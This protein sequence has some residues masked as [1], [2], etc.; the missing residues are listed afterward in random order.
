VFCGR[1][2]DTRYDYYNESNTAGDI[3]T[4]T[5]T[6]FIGYLMTGLVTGTVTTATSGTYLSN[7][8]FLLSTSSV[9]LNGNGLS[10]CSTQTFSNEPFSNVVNNIM[11]T[12]RG[13]FWNHP[14]TSF[15]YLEF[16]QRGKYGSSAFPTQSVSFSPTTNSS[17]K[18]IYQEITFS[19]VMDQVFNQFAVQPVGLATQYYPSAGPYALSYKTNTLTTYDVSTTQALNNATMATAQ[20]SNTELRIYSVTCMDAAQT[21]QKLNTF[22]VNDLVT[23][24]WRG[25]D[26]YAVIEGIEVSA[27]PTAAYYTF[28]LSA[29]QT[30]DYLVLNDSVLGRLDYNKLGF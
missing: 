25:T 19:S 18:Q 22:D 27:T 1:I 2:I 23:V 12:E 3:L 13:H 4:I 7:A 24:N 28:Y 21:T 30:I 11:Q 10:T 20:F 15:N 29:E 5:C 17:T 8:V 26:Y 6:D 14:W 9:A 16:S